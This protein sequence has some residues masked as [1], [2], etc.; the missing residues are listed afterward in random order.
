MPRTYWTIN[1]FFGAVGL[2]LS[3]LVMTELVPAIYALVAI[4]TKAAP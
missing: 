3:Y 4:Q 2:W 1:I